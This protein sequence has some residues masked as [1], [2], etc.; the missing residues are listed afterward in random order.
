MLDKIESL[1]EK[2]KEE[3]QKVSSQPD[4]LNLKSSYLGEKRGSLRDPKVFKRR[5]S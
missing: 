4:V 1:F 5:H 3:I 2:F